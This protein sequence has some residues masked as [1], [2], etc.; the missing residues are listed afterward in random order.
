MAQQQRS[1]VARSERLTPGIRAK[2]DVHSSMHNSGTPFKSGGDSTRPRSD[3]SIVEL[4][5]DYLV[6]L[7]LQIHA[8]IDDI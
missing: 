7:D 1:E 3:W 6:R 8:K 4:F 2:V 5:T